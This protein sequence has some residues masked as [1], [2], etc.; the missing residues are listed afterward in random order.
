MLR[1]G[2]LEFIDHRHRVTL[3][4]RLCQLFAA[5]ALQGAVQP[6][7]QVVKP[8]LGALAL[9]LLNGSAD[10]AERARH[11]QVAQRQGF[12]KQLVDRREQR[13]PRR[14]AFL[15]LLQ[16]HRLAK[17]IQFLRQLVVLSLLPAPFADLV[18]PVRQVFAAVAALIDTGLGD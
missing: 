16:Q 14:L 17:F 18:Q 5:T 7:E 15:G 13:M 6:A 12:I 11:D 2:I 10:L 8:Q 1:I 9:F 3:A 4:D